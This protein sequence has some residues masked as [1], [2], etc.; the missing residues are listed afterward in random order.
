MEGEGKGILACAVC[1]SSDRL[2]AGRSL[3]GGH[4]FECSRCGFVFFSPIPS[5]NSPSASAQ[6]V[7]TDED[8]TKGML[9]DPASDAVRNRWRQMAVKR[10]A[11]YQRYLGRSR[12]R[13][14]E[15]GCGTAELG[16]HFAD[17]G[18]QYQGIDIDSRC[19]EV[20]RQRSAALVERKDFLELDGD[21]RFDVVCFSQ[22]LEHIVDP[23][24]FVEKVYS[25]LVSDGVAHCDVPNHCGLASVLSRL[26]LNRD[27]LR[28]GGIQYP[29]HLFAYRKRSLLRLFS[30]WF[31][32]KVVGATSSHPCWGQPRT[33]SS[34]AM[35]TAYW[36]ACK[37]L[38]MPNLLVV[39]GKKRATPAIA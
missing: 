22:V 38:R 32:A 20:A 21:R 3:A 25:Q 37:V 13:L 29:F 26:R 1:G 27:P 23:R 35:H 19:V 17:L 8:Y 30:Q 15:I 28:W 39:I 5:A 36:A 34:G 24:R 18:V 16:P 6:S 31:D 7:Q 14:L 11:I 9:D 33:Q 10:H 2:F 4:V 12:Y